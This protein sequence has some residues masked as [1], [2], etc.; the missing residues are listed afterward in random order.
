M[1]DFVRCKVC[2]ADKTKQRK[3][4]MKKIMIALAA[5]ALAS[6]SH[7]A[8]FAWQSYA[9]QYV[10]QAG[11]STKLSGATAYLFDSSVVS[12]TA[13]LSALFAEGDDKKS[14]TDFTAL[15]TANLSSSGTIAKNNFDA[16]DV[17]VTL[18]AYFAIVDG[19]NVFISSVVSGV[20]PNTGTT[21]LSFKGLST[22][23]KAEAVEFTGTASAAGWYTAVPEP[24]SGLLML[25]G[26]AGLALR[27]RR[28]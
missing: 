20:G 5:I 1:S 13:L 2:R 27:R 15:S 6:A 24:T 23:S 10:Y 9:G 16:V 12:Q 28:A 4:K 18:N 8:A 7:A 25:V 3:M 17:G 26:L 11:S 21:T 19:D 22:P 14:I